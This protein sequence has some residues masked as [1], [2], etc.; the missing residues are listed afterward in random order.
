MSMTTNHNVSQN[1]LMNVEQALKDGKAKTA[2]QIA[3]AIKRDYTTVYRALT[4]LM[5]KHRVDFTKKG[6]F[7]LF[8]SKVTPPVAKSESP[9]KHVQKF[10]MNGNKVIHI[11][12][13]VRDFLLK[14][15]PTALVDVVKGLKT[16]R[17]TTY[18]AIAEQRRAGRLD[19]EEGILSLPAPTLPGEPEVLTNATALLVPGP[20]PV[21]ET[22]TADLPPAPEALLGGLVRSLTETAVEQVIRTLV[23]AHPEVAVTLQKK[24]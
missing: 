11:Q 17:G 8:F 1:T 13:E 21:E 2:P 4:V 5:S 18:A 6:R 16:P 3:K 14:N 7:K 20:S 19:Y 24:E 10:V 9:P 23:Q 22:P 12:N 15:G